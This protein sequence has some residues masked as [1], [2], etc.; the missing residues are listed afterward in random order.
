[1]RGRSRGG[2]V[3]WRECVVV[4]VIVGVRWFVDEREPDVVDVESSIL[5]N[6]V[7]CVN[8]YGFSDA[9]CVPVFDGCDEF[10]VFPV[11]AMFRL[12]SVFHDG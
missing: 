9:S 11:D 12:L 5:C 7:V 10:A 6:S 4:V 2:N 1:M 3:L 8:F